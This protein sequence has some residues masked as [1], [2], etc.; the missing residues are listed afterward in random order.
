[1]Q[2][3]QVVAHFLV[4]ADQH[5]PKTVHPTMRT[6]HHPPPG[7]EPSLLLQRLGFLAPCPDMCREAEL[8]EQLPYLVIIIAFVQTQPLVGVWGGVWPLHSYVLDGLAR[9]LE[10]IPIRAGHG[11]P[12]RHATAIGADAAFGADLAAVRGVLAHL[13][14]P[15]G[16]LWSSPRPSPATPSQSPA[17]HRSLPGPFPIRPQRHLPPPTLGN[18]DGRN[19][20]NRSAS[21][22]AHSTGNRCE[23]QKRWHPWL[24]DRQRGADGI[25]KGVVCAVGAR[26]Q[27]APTIRLGYASHDALSRGHQASA[28]LLEESMVSHRISWQWPTEI[29]SKPFF[30]EAFGPPNHLEFLGVL[31]EAKWMTEPMIEAIGFHPAV[32]EHINPISFLHEIVSTGEVVY[33]RTPMKRMR[34]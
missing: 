32:L 23:A 17:R 14:P 10:I 31:S 8:V 29:A 7:F 13:F 15:R 5:A 6:F 16:E 26:A 1:M 34:A 19:Y 4:P 22:S 30:S 11:Q 20:W 12:E 33:Q 3:P 28:R 21:R 2:K 27:C 18:G 9:Q 24:C 25:P